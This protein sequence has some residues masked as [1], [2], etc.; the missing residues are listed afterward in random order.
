[1]FC[2]LLVIIVILL[3][4]A[5]KFF[6]L[7]NLSLERSVQ[8]IPRI[9]DFSLVMNKG[10]AFGLFSEHKEILFGAITLSLIFLLMFLLYL[11]KKKSSKNSSLDMFAYSLIIAGAIGNWIDRLRFSAVVDFIDFKV[12]PVF[13]VADIAISVGVGLYFIYAFKRKGN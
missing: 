3:D 7:K 13:N 12:W 2:Y 4:Q 1:M 5:T 9:L 8:I 10:V 6:A 11:N